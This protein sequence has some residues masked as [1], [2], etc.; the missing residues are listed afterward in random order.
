MLVSQ[1]W[2]HV[3]KASVDHDEKADVVD[4]YT[5]CQNSNQYLRGQTELMFKKNLWILIMNIFHTQSFMI[6]LLCRQNIDKSGKQ[7][8][9]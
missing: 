2:W 5:R 4:Y 1:S 9:F 3:E 7:K 6:S 8:H